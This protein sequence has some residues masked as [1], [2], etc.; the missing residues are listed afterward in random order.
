[1][2]ASLAILVV[3]LGGCGNS[4]TATDSLCKGTVTVT[5]VSFASDWESCLVQVTGDGRFS[6]GLVARSCP[7]DGACLLSI[8]APGPGPQRCDNE[9][10][11]VD[12]AD[13]AFGGPIHE[14]VAGCSGDCPASAVGSCTVDSTKLDVKGWSGTISAHLVDSPD[15]TTSADITVSGSFT[16]PL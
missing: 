14:L 8:V 3:A 7:A 1:V 5:G 13:P 12:V 4:S 16:N 2:R 9:S 10:T 6:L 15:L 11:S